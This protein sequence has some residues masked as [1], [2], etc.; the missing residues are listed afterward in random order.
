MTREEVLQVAKQYLESL[1]Q[2]EDHLKKQIFELQ[3]EYNKIHQEIKSLTW[4]VKLGEE[5]VGPST[6]FPLEEIMATREIAATSDTYGPYEIKNEIAKILADVYP[7]TMHYTKIMEKLN[8]RGFFIGGKNPTQNLLSYLS[9]DD[10]FVRGEK[11]GE[12]RLKISEDVQ[13]TIA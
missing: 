2:K 1:K 8:E 5:E 10:R 13:K 7:G 11:R 3:Q 6:G 12:Y 9:R 4:F